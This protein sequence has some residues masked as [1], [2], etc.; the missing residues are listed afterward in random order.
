[1]TDGGSTVRTAGLRVE[2]AVL[3]VAAVVL[4][5]HVL[6]AVS[7]GG[8]VA[9]PDIPSYLSVAQWVAGG[10]PPPPF[11]YHPGYGL[12]LGPVALTGI[13]PDGLHTAAL[14][15]N[16]VLAAG[17]VVVAAALVRVLAPGAPRWVTAVA[18]GLTALHPSL[19]SASRVAWTETVLIALVLGTALA[20]ARAARGPGS[21]WFALAGGLATV[22]VAAHPRMAALAA[23]SAL[24][25]VVV[26]PG[27][28]AAASYVAGAAIGAATTVVALVVAYTGPT[29]GGRLAGAV[30]SAGEG[31]GL[32]TTVSGQLAAVA[33]STAGLALVGLVEAVRRSVG[34]L[35]REPP[36]PG[37]E[38]ATVAVGVLLGAGAI[39]T[40]LVAGASLAGSDRADTFAYG[41]YLDPY[42]VALAVLAL[43]TL[44]VRNRHVVGSALMVVAAATALVWLSA[45]L[46]ARP[47]TRIMVMGTDQ[48][49]R[50]SDGRL[51]P[52]LLAGFAVA[53]L[54]LAGWLAAERWPGATAA[55]VALGLLLA[56]TATATSQDH[57]ARVGEVSAG[58]ATAAAVVRAMGD[59]TPDCLAHDRTEVATY[60]L[61]LYR[62]Q[63][64]DL[65]HQRV[66]LSAGE[67]PCSSLVVAHLT[68]ST[69]AGCPDASVLATEP[70]GTWGLWEVP[71]GACVTGAG[72][73]DH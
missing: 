53:A 69:L 51:V 67:A 55:P 16:G 45:D 14:V 41:R 23:A 9:V 34:G 30:E 10:Q 43:A 47:A 71:T 61:W 65:D 38:R 64:P 62:M 7:H 40:L 73:D 48:W 31:A 57:L 32:I 29:G 3:V 59:D 25:V 6:V 13:G 46:V 12:L 39:G 37:L 15:L 22:G 60:V 68:E 1:V 8:P 18:V 28:R 5:G 70:K 17:A 44:A 36:A 52:A 24:A 4:V 58:Q 11:G 49:W 56:V 50:L 2:H 63:L 33:A 72:G 19:T 35:R 26:R 27:W 66:D 42:T 20:I 21:A 54:G